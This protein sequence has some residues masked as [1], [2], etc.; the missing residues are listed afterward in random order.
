[1]D[2]AVAGLPWAGESNF[3]QKRPRWVWTLRISIYIQMLLAISVL[4][5]PYYHEIFV[6]STVPLIGLY[7]SHGTMHHFKLIFVAFVNV[8]SFLAESTKAFYLG[9]HYYRP[10][11]I[12]QLHRYHHDLVQRRME[13]EEYASSG[14]GALHWDQ[15]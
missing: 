3:F 5:T 4:L 10:M 12:E 13:E 11:D 9:R 6:A 1:M 15:A 2:S 7:G 8:P 14:D